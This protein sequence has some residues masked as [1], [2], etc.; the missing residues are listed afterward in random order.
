[1]WIRLLETDAEREQ[2]FRLVHDEYVREGYIQP[3][4]DSRFVHHCGLWDRIPFTDVFIAHDDNGDLIGTNSLTR[5]NE[6]GIHTLVD[7]PKETMR[8]RLT[9]KVLASSWRIVTRNDCKAA[10]GL[11]SALIRATVQRAK[12]IGVETC[13]FTFNPKHMCRYHIALNMEMIG[14]SEVTEGIHAP[15]VLMRVATKDVPDRWFK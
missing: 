10:S 5:D 9:G 8:E 13:L 11:V 15:S 14:F 4:S 12:A 2:V 1:M 6:Y 3:Q 7:F